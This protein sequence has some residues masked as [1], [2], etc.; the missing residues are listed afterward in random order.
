MPA[1]VPPSIHP[2]GKPY[3]WIPGKSPADI[4]LAELDEIPP[5]LLDHWSNISR[6]PARVDHGPPL[7]QSGSFEAAIRAWLGTRTNGKPLREKANG[8]IEGIICPW[9][10]R[11]AQGNRHPSFSVHFGYGAWKCWSACDS[12]GLRELA[13]S[14]GITTV[15][16]RSRPGRRASVSVP[17]R[18]N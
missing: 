7:P 2:T 12:G 18:G 9:T 17:A 1:I 6:A 4:P 15:T 11:H 14:F 8:W 5:L 10:E 3:A 13:E 16:R